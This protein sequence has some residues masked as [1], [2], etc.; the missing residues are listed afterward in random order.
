M[1]SSSNPPNK[2]RRSEDLDLETRRHAGNAPRASP[3]VSQR[4]N[5]LGATEHCCDGFDTN[6]ASNDV[7]LGVQK[8]GSFG[9]PI[10]FDTWGVSS[11]NQGGCAQLSLNWSKTSLAVC[12]CVCVFSFQRASLAVCFRLRFW[13]SEIGYEIEKLYQAVIILASLNCFMNVDFS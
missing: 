6:N 11:I 7:L 12:V 2:I 10:G 9:T 8:G 3:Q 5:T 1:N 4:P 13:K